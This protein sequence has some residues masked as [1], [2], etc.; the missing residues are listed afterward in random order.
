MIRNHYYLWSYLGFLVLCWNIM[1]KSNLRRNAFDLHILYH[2]SPRE[3]KVWTLSRWESGGRSWGKS[4]GGLL[5]IFLLKR[6]SQPK[7]FHS[8]EGL[9]RNITI[10][11]SLD[12]RRSIIKKTTWSLI[13]CSHFLYGLSLCSD[14][15][16]CAKLI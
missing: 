13:L 9:H 10:H 3:V 12:P 1:T 2:Y 6:I 15:Y 4:H 7:F 8:T 5:F 11:I 14:Y 16:S